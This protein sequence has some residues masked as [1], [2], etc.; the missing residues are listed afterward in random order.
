MEGPQ[1]CTS[2]ALIEKAN[3]NPDPVE[4]ARSGI[5]ESWIKEDTEA[6]ELAHQK[7]SQMR[8]VSVETLVAPACVIPDLDNDNPRTY[9][10]MRPRNT[11]A[12]MFDDWLDEPH[13][14]ELMNHRSRSYSSQEKRQR[15]E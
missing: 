14:R 2:Y 8:L 12:L 4:A 7:W 5:F 6:E 11:W 10:R 1:G 3:L 13:L 15:D 9:L